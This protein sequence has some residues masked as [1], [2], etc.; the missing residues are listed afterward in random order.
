[1]EQKGGW[2]KRFHPGVLKKLT[3][4][5]AKL[6]DLPKALFWMTH[7]I[8]WALPG[9]PEE[10]RWILGSVSVKVESLEETAWHSLGRHPSSSARAVT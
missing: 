5:T 3:D 8:T 6:R 1:M 2:V 10:C 7:K 4:K 9:V